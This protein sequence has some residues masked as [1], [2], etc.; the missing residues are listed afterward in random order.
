MVPNPV[1]KGE[2]A[3]AHFPLML[4]GGGG[5]IVAGSQRND[6]PNEIEAL[7]LRVA[8]NQAAIALREAQ[9][10]T[11]VQAARAEAET[12]SRSKDEFLAVLS[13][14]LRT[15][16]NAI[17]GWARML[18][19]GNFDEATSARALET[20]ER[21]AKAQAQLIEDLLDVSRIITGKLRLEVQ[22]VELAAVIETAIDV[23]RPAAEAKEI[24]FQAKLDYFAGPVSGDP[25][26]LQQVAWNIL[27]NAV[28]FT[29]KGGRVEVLLERV[30]SNIEI[31][32]T[33]TGI[34]ISPEFLPYVFDRFRQ[35]DA[36]LSRRHGGL[37]LG[38]AIVR[39]LVELHDGSVSIYSGGEK[40][41][42]TFKI[43]LPLMATHVTNGASAC[44]EQI[45]PA[46]ISYG[47]PINSPQ[48]LA[49]LH[50]LVV[51]DDL[52]ARRLMTEILM[53]CGAEVT[54]V[55]SAAEALEALESLKPHLL[56][57]DI[58]MPDE[59]GYSLIRKVRKMEAQREER[60]PAI[61]LTAHARAEDRLRALSEGYQSHIAKPVEPSELVAAIADMTGRQNKT[62][63]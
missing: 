20:I 39:N 17:L 44:G 13:H 59:D 11:R 37:G 8:T 41:G 26:R 1:G 18:R 50:L 63:G 62:L 33:D 29:P 16:L 5:I 15:P 28:K 14:E 35:A 45:E 46:T 21:N 24:T 19:T 56:V 9:L 47:L 2:V 43:S 4:Q 53:R 54:A 61:A 23:L 40:Q 55:A 52:D 27:S 7:L 42:T 25:N 12:A 34:G 58:E 49:G 6:F 38:L 60:L 48:S 31:T 57:S 36:S 22:A 10:L 3:L 51:D 30:N 32:V